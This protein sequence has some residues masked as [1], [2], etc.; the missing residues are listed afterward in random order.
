MLRLVQANISQ[1]HKW[2]PRLQL[3]GLRQ[4]VHLMQSPGLENVTHIIWPETAVPYAIE[5]GSPLARDLGGSIPAGKFLITGALRLDGKEDD[6]K[7][8][9][10]LV[11][12]DHNG[13]IVGSYDKYR[14]VPFGEFL[15]LRSIL[16]KAWLTPVGDKD[17]SRGPGA[18]T[19]ELPGFPAISPLICYEG[20]FPGAVID[21]SHRPQ[22]LLNVTNDAWF[23]MSTGPHQHFEMSRMRAV[24]QAIPL[25]RVANTGISAIVDSYGRVAALP[26]RHAGDY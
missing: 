1:P 14:L 17:F 18:Q 24:E 6:F 4:Y 5:A 23:G 15:P 22:L 12:L 11:A 25:V 10:S 2:D 19:L 7:I 9:N 13:G 16:P 21:E 3:Q 20:I 8:W 26:L